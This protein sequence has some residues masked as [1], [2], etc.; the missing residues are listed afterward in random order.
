MLRPK[1][2]KI[3]FME[4]QPR[5]RRRPALACLECRRRKIK[6][7]RSE[8]CTHCVPTRTQCTYKVF[9]NDNEPVLP[10]PPDG[11][12]APSPSP[13]AQIQQI[14]TNSPITEYGNHQSGSCIAAAAG[15]NDTP[16]T[17]TLGRSD[18]RPLSRAHAEDPEPDLRDL[19]QRIQRLEKSLPSKTNHGLSE[20]GPDLV[21]RQSGL[22]DAQISVNKTRVLRWSH[23]M[24]AAQSEVQ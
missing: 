14:N 19:L 9:S 21:A 23:G 11:A 17:S 20:T 8:P 2:F 10:T 6:C 15:Q 18:I 1:D 5:R 22:Q 24:G 12:Y 7:D 4:R 16:N 3:I 13:L